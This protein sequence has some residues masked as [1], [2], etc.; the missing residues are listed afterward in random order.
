MFITFL[1]THDHARKKETKDAW[2]EVLVHCLKK[3]N[4]R[5]SQITGNMKANQGAGAVS[6]AY[7]H[8]Q[9]YSCDRS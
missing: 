1:R 6:Q 3:K 9:V 4:A 2:S 7:F 8:T 5:E